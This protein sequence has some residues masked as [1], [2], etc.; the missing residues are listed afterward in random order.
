MGGTD[1]AVD[2]PG[3]I[4]EDEDFQNPDDFEE[5]IDVGS[6]D[7]EGDD[8]MVP[9]PRLPLLRS[10]PS[11]RPQGGAGESSGGAPRRTRKPHGAPT[12]LHTPAMPT[13]PVGHGKVRLVAPPGS[14]PTRFP[15]VPFLQLLVTQFSQN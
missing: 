7:M 5:E 4:G 14:R 15:L 3:V 9:F 11:P 6:V 2:E 12:S 10:A 8:D 1:G 13:G